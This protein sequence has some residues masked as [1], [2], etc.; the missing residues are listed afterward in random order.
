VEQIE[1][2]REQEKNNDEMV[3]EESPRL[4]MRNKLLGKL[5]CTCK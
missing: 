4:D 1:K 2:T 3:F 5:I